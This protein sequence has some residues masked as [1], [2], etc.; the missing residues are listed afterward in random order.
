MTRYQREC[1]FKTPFLCCNSLYK[2][3]DFEKF[4]DFTAEFD[5][6]CQ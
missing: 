5:K 1:G 4:S 6:R 2:D 3:L